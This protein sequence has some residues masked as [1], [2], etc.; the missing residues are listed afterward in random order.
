MLTFG[1]SGC[2]VWSFLVAAPENKLINTTMRNEKA[3][4]K[5][6]DT[7]CLETLVTLDGTVGAEFG[8]GRFTCCSIL[9]PSAA[10]VLEEKINTHRYRKSNPDKRRQQHNNHM[11]IKTEEK[12]KSKKNKRSS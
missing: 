10:D 5:Q 1:F 9:V 4:E 3:A 7:H 2:G 6:Q 11:G 12:K 8:L